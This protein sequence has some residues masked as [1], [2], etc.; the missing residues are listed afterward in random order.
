MTASPGRTGQAPV[1][2]LAV[3]GPARGSR[4]DVPAGGLV[5]GRAAGSAGRL[6]DDPALSRWHARLDLADEGLAVEDLASTNGTLLNG[7]ADQRPPAGPAGR[8]RDPRR[9]PAA[10]AAAG[11]E[12]P[13]RNCA[14]SPPPSCRPW[15]PRTPHHRHRPPRP[16]PRTPPRHR[17]PRPRPR[18]PRPRPRPPHPRPRPRPPRARPHRPRHRP[19][20]T[21]HRPRRPP[22]RP[23]RP[24]PLRPP[25][26]RTRQA[27]RARPRRARHRRRTRQARQ[28]QLRRTRS[29]PRPLV[30]S[31]AAQGTQIVVP[32]GG[33]IFGRGG[34]PQGQLGDDP[35]L[36]RLHAVIVHSGRGELLVSDVGSANGTFL[37]GSRVEGA[38]LVRAGDVIEL[39]STKLKASGPLTGAPPAAGETT[40]AARPAP[41]ASRPAAAPGSPGSP[42]P[43]DHR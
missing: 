28:A 6:G 3:S 33:L 26:R 23:G 29:R 14:R 22:R 36:S 12:P 42:A 21:R 10:G 17:P 31:G 20:H 9:L 24:R 5:F 7:A 30:V 35:A 13:P 2:L 1:T 40:P 43:A 4:I 19:P 25:P 16:R 8:R 34:S 38:T 11:S 15:P 37:N 32:R 39:G 27:R 41:A 18:P